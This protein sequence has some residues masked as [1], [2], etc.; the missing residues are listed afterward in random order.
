MKIVK[1]FVVLIALIMI[2]FSVKASSQNQ[3]KLNELLDLR[4]QIIDIENNKVKREIVIE[5]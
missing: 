2:S 1:S 3:L 4:D 5:K